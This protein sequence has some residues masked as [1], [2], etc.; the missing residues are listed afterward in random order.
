MEV[1][2]CKLALTQTKYHFNTHKAAM[3]ALLTRVMELT[4]ETKNCDIY[5]YLSGVINP[6]DKTRREQDLIWLSNSLKYG[7]LDNGIALHL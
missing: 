7:H 4:A 3:G 6:M 1:S 2:L 5:T